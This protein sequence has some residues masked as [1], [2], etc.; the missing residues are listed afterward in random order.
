MAELQISVGASDSRALPQTWNS[1]FQFLQTFD[2]CYTEPSHPSM[3]GLQWFADCFFLMFLEYFGVFFWS[4]HFPTENHRFTSDSW[5]PLAPSPGKSWARWPSPKPVPWRSW[6]DCSQWH[7]TGR[8][9]CLGL[10]GTGSWSRYENDT[11]TIYKT[12]MIYYSICTN[13]Q[14]TIEL[15]VHLP[16]YVCI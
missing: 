14:Y 8:E 15:P 5:R 3:K 1:D 4:R 6:S 2:R 7:I 13:I 12:N 10:L 16:T 11:N 9:R